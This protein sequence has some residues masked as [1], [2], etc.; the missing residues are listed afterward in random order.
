MLRLCYSYLMSTLCSGQPWGTVQQGPPPSPSRPPPTT[1]P[2]PPSVPQPPS[3]PPPPPPPIPP[4]SPP[5]PPPIPPPPSKGG[6]VVVEIILGLLAVGGLA[7]LSACVYGVFKPFDKSLS[8]S[9]P[10][11]TRRIESVAPG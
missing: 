3:T 6:E 7:G 5:L 1:P 10:K 8:S 9:M 2:S 4:P 11:M